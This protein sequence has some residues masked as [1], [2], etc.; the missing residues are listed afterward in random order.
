MF[1][2]ECPNCVNYRTIEDVMNVP[3][4]G[5]HGLN[6]VVPDVHGNPS[7][8]FQCLSCGVILNWVMKVRIDLSTYH[9]SAPY[10]LVALD[11]AS[12]FEVRPTIEL[13]YK[14][15]EISLNKVSEC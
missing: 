15:S 5:L 11:S 12:Y 3:L 8:H 1:R 9:C 6:A 4:F 2:F 13:I 10:M 7:I 14:T